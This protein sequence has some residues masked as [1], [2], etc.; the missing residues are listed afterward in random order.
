MK[1]NVGLALA[2]ACALFLS[3]P[4]R[5][6]PC[7]DVTVPLSTDPSGQMFAS[8]N[9]GG[10]Q[11]TSDSNVEFGSRFEPGFIDATVSTDIRVLLATA[12]VN[13]VPFGGFGEGTVTLKVALQ[14]GPGNV[15]CQTEQQLANQAS[16]WPG[17][18]EIESVTLPFVCNATRQSADGT[19]VVVVDLDASAAAYGG[20][21]VSASASIQVGALELTLCE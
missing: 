7:I 18:S 16:A 21:A 6:A 2:A 8:A 19:Y 14:D 9:V 10:A 11:S 15:L 20:V 5:A 4:A 3:R 13:A 12:G 1:R 17:S